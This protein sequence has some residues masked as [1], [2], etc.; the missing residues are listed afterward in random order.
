LL[1]TFSAIVSF[2]FGMALFV[3][4][5][6]WIAGLF[7][8]IISNHIALNLIEGFVRLSILLGYIKAIT[9][10]HYVRRVFQYHGAEHKIVHAVEQGRPLLPQNTYDLSTVHPRC[11]TNFMFLV[12]V[13]KVVLFSLLS[14]GPLWQ[15]VLWRLLMLPLVAGV[16]YELLKMGA[17]PRFAWM[18]RLVLLPGLWAQKHLTTRE[19]SD[20][21][22]EVA[23]KAMEAVL[24]REREDAVEPQE[25]T[26]PAV[27]SSAASPQ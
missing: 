25:Q 26:Y 9:Y 13:V 4:L 2:A 24:R 3:A 14:W 1:A 18:T 21:Q 6:T 27:S 12:I 16:S 23:I 8:G 19:P 17:N 20:D 11:G 22:V 10:M 5:P 7:K 15:R